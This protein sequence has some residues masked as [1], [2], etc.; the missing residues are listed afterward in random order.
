MLTPSPQVKRPV[1]PTASTSITWNS[2]LVRVEYRLPSSANG[3]VSV[4]LAGPGLSQSRTWT[5]SNGNGR[6]V[7]WFD[8]NRTGS[9]TRGRD[10]VTLSGRNMDILSIS[11]RPERPQLL[12]DGGYYEYVVLD[13]GITQGTARA[14]A[15]RSVYLSRVGRLA[16]IKTTTI[17]NEL[18]KEF[19]LDAPAWVDANRPNDAVNV[20]VVVGN[21]A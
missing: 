11:V 15:K 10:Q 19:V 14:L 20:E 5:T 21:F 4:A 2:F 8:A 9:F 18:G 16:R 7:A 1:E 13:H 6:V 17:F 12:S 3:S